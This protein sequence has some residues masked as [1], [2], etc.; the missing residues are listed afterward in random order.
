MIGMVGC[1]GGEGAITDVR[2]RWCGT[3]LDLLL[4]GGGC[5]VING[6]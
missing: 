2:R 4:E 5:L 3:I 6:D 1:V